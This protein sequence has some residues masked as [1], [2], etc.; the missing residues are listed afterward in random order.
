MQF[1]FVAVVLIFLAALSTIGAGQ[2]DK[3]LEIGSQF[4]AL[5]LY[6]IGEVTASVGARASYELH[7]MGLT[8]AP[9]V[10]V[11]YFPQD[12]SGDFGEMQFMAGARTGVS[13]GRRAFFIKTR[14]GLVHFG[15]ADFTERTGRS[16]TNFAFD[17]GGVYEHF[18]SPHMAFRLDWGDTM[19]RFSSP[20]STAQFSSI[21]PGWSHNL[22]TACGVVFRF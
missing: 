17:L 16:S 2:T 15:G 18:V 9:E 19:I 12:S 8:I 5:R 20:S 4:T 22:Q 1:R 14:P 11:N 13:I 10:E 21:K 6:T 7:F 3:P